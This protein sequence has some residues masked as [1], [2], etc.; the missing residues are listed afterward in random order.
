M[1][2]IAKSLDALRRQV[3]DAWPDRDKASDGWIGD[4]AHRKRES[5]HNP[6]ADGSV[7]ALDITHDPAS[8]CDCG[9]IAEAIRGSR[10]ARV[11]YL[12][13][14]R[15]IVSPPSWGWRGYTGSNP[16]TTHLHVSVNDDLQDDESAWTIGD[17]VT[18]PDD[19]KFKR[20]VGPLFT[21]EGGF[22]PDDPSN[23][24]ITLDTLSLHIGKR[25]TLPML[26]ALKRSE[27]ETIYRTLYW[28]VIR[29]DRL[30][31]GLDV[32][33][34]DFAVH[35]GPHWAVLA[36]QKIV[37]GVREDGAM[38][39]RTLEAVNAKDVIPMIEALM[40]ARFARMK[41]RPNWQKYKNN[42]TARIAAVRTEALDVAS[43]RLPMPEP[44]SPPT[45]PPE[46]S[47]GALTDAIKKALG[48]KEIT[49]AITQ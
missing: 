29:G 34:F 32:A 28:N 13:F 23:M 21:R 39:P 8:G 3:D 37:G 25:A 44:T 19:S 22:N 1:A 24:G 48:A 47:V 9:K 30:P 45:P 35:S 20:A 15:R 40:D 18:V 16:H 14:N 17:I 10:D 36:L 26:K 31:D 11:K 33:L 41:T 49:I 6:D 46:N 4:A 27:A 38:G 43:L 12:I 5:D 2:R 42:W 7:D